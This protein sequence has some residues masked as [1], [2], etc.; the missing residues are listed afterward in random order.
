MIKQKLFR[1]D[2]RP[3]QILEVFG[4]GFLGIDR[5][6]RRIDSWFCKVTQRQITVQYP[7]DVIEILRWPWTIQAIFMTQLFI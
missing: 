5:V 1:I 6:T 3:D 2:Q 7:R 4:I